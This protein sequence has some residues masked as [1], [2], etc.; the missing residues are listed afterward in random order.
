MAKPSAINPLNY[1]INRQYK[2]IIHIKK[3]LFGERLTASKNL[4]QK[5]LFSHYGCVN[6][7]EFS[8]EGELMVSG[9]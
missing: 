6:A 7:I 9:N 8:A 3:K 5:D 4:Y 2:D 1:I